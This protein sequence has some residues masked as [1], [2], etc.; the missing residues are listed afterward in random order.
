MTKRL[1]RIV[2]GVCVILAVAMTARADG[3][4]TTWKA[5][6]FY[7]SGD[8]VAFNGIIYQVMQAHTSQVGWEP[9]K[10]PSLFLR[11]V[12]RGCRPWQVQTSYGVGSIA[13]FGN[14]FFRALQAHDSLSATWTPD[15]SPSLWGEV[16]GDLTCPI[17]AKYCCLSATAGGGAI[18][19]KGKGCV[20]ISDGNT[21]SC[22]ID[23][24]L[25]VEVTCDDTQIFNALS[26]ELT[27]F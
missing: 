21:G 22:R 4:A 12:P 7:E 1:S 24:I 23:G 9:S 3:T 15:D 13:K 17:E 2:V 25:N 14:K 16:P 26:G 18:K 19:V 8:Q 20:K 10:V 11:P 6:T 5:N 27:C